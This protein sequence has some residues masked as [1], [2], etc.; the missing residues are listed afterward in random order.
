M[1]RIPKPHPEV[2][3]VSLG[4]TRSQHTQEHCWLVLQEPLDPWTLDQPFQKLF[5]L[6]LVPL[7]VS[8][9]YFIL[10]TIVAGS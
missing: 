2:W 3:R 8:L 6:L 1:P 4:G 10:Y 7:V 9:P 5:D